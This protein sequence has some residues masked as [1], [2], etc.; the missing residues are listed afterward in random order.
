MVNLRKTGKKV[1]FLDVSIGQ[2]FYA[3]N[4]FWVRISYEGASELRA[5]L[6]HAATCCNFTIDA[7]DE[8]VEEVESV[9]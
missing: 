6:C 5:S 8:F 9:T 2:P 4:R 3:H 7:E 1:R